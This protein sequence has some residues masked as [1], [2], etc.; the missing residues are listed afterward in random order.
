MA[1]P[2]KNPIVKVAIMVHDI[3]PFLKKSGW[4]NVMMEGMIKADTVH[5]TDT[6][7]MEAS[8]SIELFFS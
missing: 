6:A 1:S 7:L 4:T 8:E 2:K 5:A 3:E